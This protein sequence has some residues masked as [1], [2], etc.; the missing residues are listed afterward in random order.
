MATKRHVNFGERL[1][2]LDTLGKERADSI[3][4]PAPG[5]GLEERLTAAAKLEG[6]GKSPLAGVISLPTAASVRPELDFDP[7]AYRPYVPGMPVRVGD[8]LAVPLEMVRPN[9]M[10]PRVFYFDEDI[11]D[12]S[13]SL[14]ND[15]QLQAVQAY[16]PSDDGIF[17]LHD[18]ETRWRSLKLVGHQSVELEIVARDPNPL[19][20]FKQA[21]TLNTQRKSQ[22]VFD[23]AVRFCD[24][25]SQRLVKGNVELATVFG[26]Q[27]VY[28]S[29]VLS[30][31]EMPRSVLER[32]AHNAEYFGIANAYAMYQYWVAQGRDNQAL[33][34]LV[35]KVIEGKLSVRDVKQL[36][37]Q[38]ARPAASVGRPARKR[39]RP[40]SRAEIRSGARGELKAFPDGKLQLE[41]SEIPEPSRALLFAR[42]LQLFDECGMKY[43]SVGASPDAT[44][45]LLP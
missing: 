22:T 13:I 9:A 43:E 27:E 30:I 25:L 20:R 36:L 34:K 40:L 5:P 32:M 28:V 33:E 10:N 17:E 41:L 18:G 45:R 1:D 2:R 23:D 42:I 35:N 19:V 24:L 4:G 26:L 21:R 38:S 14:A 37:D 39:E 29:K 16:P 11:R 15:G 7:G 3:V 12:R 44:G 6:M 8:R 31:G